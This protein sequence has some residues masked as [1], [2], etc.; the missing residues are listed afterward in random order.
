MVEAEELAKKS[1]SAAVSMRDLDQT[2]LYNKEVAK[3]TDQLLDLSHSMQFQ[4]QLVNKTA[5]W[6]DVWHVTISC[7]S[8]DLVFYK[9]YLDWCANY[10][11]YTPGCC[12][13]LDGVGILKL[14][15]LE[16]S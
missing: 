2:T 15:L 11:L 16:L 4:S 1:K 10:E 8:R 9:H 14:L 3:I 13:D 5:V 7:K 12:N 6:R